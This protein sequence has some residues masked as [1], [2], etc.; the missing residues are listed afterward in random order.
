MVDAPARYILEELY[1]N[2][3]GLSKWNPSVLQSNKIQ[4]IDEYTDVSY[5]VSANAGGGVISSRDF[6]TLRHWGIEEGSYVIACKG[7]ELK[8]VPKQPSY[9]R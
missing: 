1:Y 6:V 2:I 8:S 5:Q 7:I 4:T 9:V 3:E